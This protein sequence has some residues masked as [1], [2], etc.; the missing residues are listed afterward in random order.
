MRLEDTDYPEQAAQHP[1]RCQRVAV[2][3]A[4]DVFTELVVLDAHH[5]DHDLTFFVSDWTS[6]VIDA[7]KREPG[8]GEAPELP[9]L[10]LFIGACCEVEPADPD[11][12]PYLLFSGD[13][14]R[15]T[16]G[17]SVSLH[18]PVAFWG[19]VLGDDDADP[20]PDNTRLTEGVIKVL[21]Q[22]V[23]R[24]GDDGDEQEQEQERAHDLL[25]RVAADLQDRQQREMEAALTSP[26]EP[27]TDDPAR[28]AL[29]EAIDTLA[30]AMPLLSPEEEAQVQRSMR[31]D[32][33]LR[34]LSAARLAEDWWAMYA[35][36]QALQAFDAQPVPPVPPVLFF[37]VLYPNRT[38]HYCYENGQNRSFSV[39]TPWRTAWGVV[40]ELREVPHPDARW[41]KRQEGVLF[42]SRRPGWLHI[43][44]WDR[45]GDERDGACACFVVPTDDIGEA[46]G[47]M[48]HHY[49]TTVARIEDRI[50]AGELELWPRAE[51]GESSV[52]L[53]RSV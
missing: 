3:F 27:A 31:R 40:G 35:A 29:R 38:G 25:R 18:D 47:A 53:E 7:M 6:F 39:A 30:A 34:K 52:A 16:P 33:L 10:G 32:G 4:R 17:E 15:L 37:G 49:K 9:A 14:R 11:D 28:A 23:A 42:I 24:S 48:R 41:H 22:T 46:L 21:P 43:G 12:E 1:E 44:I 50:G 26:C 5:G 19:K 45:S 8:E 20:D 2:L 36:N 13:V 51:Y